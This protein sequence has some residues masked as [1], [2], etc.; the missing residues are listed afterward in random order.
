MKHNAFKTTKK[1]FF[2]INNQM[3]RI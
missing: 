1:S 2:F 3:F